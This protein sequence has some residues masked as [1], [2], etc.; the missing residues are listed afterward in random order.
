MTARWST[1]LR[2]LAIAFSLLLTGRLLADDAAAEFS[3][4]NNPNGN[5][6]YGYSSTTNGSFTLM[7]GGSDGYPFESWGGGGNS[8]TYNQTGQLQWLGDTTYIEGGVMIFDWPSG[9]GVAVLR[10]TAPT[11]GV[12]AVFTSGYGGQLFHNGASLPSPPSSG[13][14]G[15]VTNVVTAAAGDTID[16]EASGGTELYQQTI[17]PYVP[18][19]TDVRI[20]M[21]SGPETGSGD[22]VVY[23]ITATNAGPASVPSLTINDSDLFPYNMT[24]VSENPST[25]TE[26]V[27]DDGSGAWLVISPFA[28]GSSVTWVLQARLQCSA[29]PI[30]VEKNTAFLSYFPYDLNTANDTASVVNVV[31]SAGGQCTWRMWFQESLAE[32]M[33]CIG[34]KKVGSTCGVVTNGQ[35]M[36]KAAT[37]AESGYNYQ[38][39]PSSFDETTPVGIQI[40]QFSYSGVLGDDPRYHAGARHATFTASHTVCNSKGAGCH[41]IAQLK[42]SVSWTDSEVKVLIIGKTPVGQSPVLADQFLGGASGPVETSTTGQ[43]ILGTS[44]LPIS[45]DVYG[46]VSMRPVA[47]SGGTLSLSAVSIVGDGGR[48]NTP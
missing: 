22:S 3:A 43:I 9:A 38:L 28:T 48:R 4:T 32:K 13:S 34:S 47:A 39:D 15:A 19:N 40:G 5:W 10:W 45:L 20:S 7:T 16:F 41:N 17:T 14:L 29:G 35:F 27:Y 24:M 2:L 18:L 11:A 26:S 42:V 23:T 12:Y 36:I 25:G 37:A 46:N 30:N 1:F 8:I 33:Q 6:S 21:T 31:G 44:N